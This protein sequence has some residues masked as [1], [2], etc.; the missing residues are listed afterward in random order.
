MQLHEWHEFYLLMGSAAAALTGLLFV[1]VSIG[2][3]V[4]GSRDPAGVRAFVTPI[5]VHFTSVG[6]VSALMLM[7]PMTAPVLAILLAVGGVGVLIYLLAIRVHKHWRKNQLGTE[8]WIAYVAVP[9]IAYLIILA[10]SMAIWRELTAGFV[11]LAA[12]TMLLLVIGIRNAWDL[13]IWMARQ[14]RQ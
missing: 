7:P 14:P 10:A 13:V 2:P 6:V 11:S 8:D 3:H 9:V 1:V 5:V 4:V 12:A